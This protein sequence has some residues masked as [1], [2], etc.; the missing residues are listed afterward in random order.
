MSVRTCEKL[1]AALDAVRRH[2]TAHN[3]VFFAF[4]DRKL[5]K[6]AV[7]HEGAGCKRELLEDGK[8]RYVTI[9]GIKSLPVLINCC[10]A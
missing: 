10:A 7:F 2:E 3:K 5:D 1:V 6:I 9:G 4:E 8:P